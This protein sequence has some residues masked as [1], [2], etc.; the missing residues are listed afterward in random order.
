M[1]SSSEPEPSLLSVFN[2]SI[3]KFF[4]NRKKGTD[5]SES[6][7]LRETLEELIEEHIEDGGQPIPSDERRLTSWSH[8]LT[9]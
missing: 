9:S 4:K 6:S 2:N 1:P 7:N 5:S 3:K 8:V